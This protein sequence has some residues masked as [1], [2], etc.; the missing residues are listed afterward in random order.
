MKHK[1]LSSL[2][3]AVGLVVSL[4]GIAMAYDPYGGYPDYGNYDRQYDD[5]RYDAYLSNQERHPQHDS[6]SGAGVAAVL[7]LVGL[8]GLSRLSRRSRGA[9]RSSGSLFRSGGGYDHNGV[10]RRWVQLNKRRKSF[11]ETGLDWP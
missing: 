1:F 5:D 11:I 8:I 9:G 3:A 10:A 2:F 4:L 6:S 7:L